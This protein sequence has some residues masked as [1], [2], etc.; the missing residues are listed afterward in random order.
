[1]NFRYTLKHHLTA[2]DVQFTNNEFT[3]TINNWDQIIGSDKPFAWSAGKA[4]AGGGATLANTAAIGQDRPDQPDLKWRPGTYTIDITAN[5]LSTGGSGPFTQFLRVFGSD[6]GSAL[7][8][9]IF[10]IG[11]AGQWD[12][13]AGESTQQITFT[14][15]QEYQKIFFKFDKSGSDVGYDVDFIIDSFEIIRVQDATDDHSI[16]EPDGWKGAKIKLDRDPEYGS[17]IEHYEGAAGGAFIFYGENGEED[18]GINFIKEIEE[19]YGLD[20]NIEFLAEYAPDDTTYTELFSGLLDLTGKNEMPNNKMQVPVIRDGF[21]AKFF[22]RKDTPVNLSD[23]IDLDGNPVDECVPITINLPSQKIRYNG[24]YRWNETVQYP[25]PGGDGRIQLDW[26][27]V[28]VD[29]LD[30]HNLPRVDV[31]STTTFNLIPGIFEAPYDGVYTFDI[32]VETGSFFGGA[33]QNALA[34]PRLHIGHVGGTD[35][36]NYPFFSSSSINNG[37]QYLWVHT[38]NGSFTLAKGQQLAIFGVTD[39]SAGTTNVFGERLNDWKTDV[40]VASTIA[41]VLSGTQT[42]DNYAAGIGDRVLVKN[43]GDPKENGI[44]VVAAGAWSRATDADSASE[45]QDAT[46]FIINGNTNA[47]T[48]WIQNTEDIILG[49]TE[50]TFRTTIYNDTKIVPYPGAGTPE[51]YLIITGETTYKES[52]AQGYLI[53]DLIHGVLARLGLGTD[54]FYSEFLGSTLTTSKQYQEDGAGWPYLILKGLQIRGYTLA[55]KPFFISFKQIWDG[56]NPILNL[57]LGY[58]VSQDSPDYQYIRIEQKAH[59]YEDNISVYF[60]DVLDISSYY[61]QDHI[62]KTIKTG[63]KDWQSEDISGIDDPQAKQTRATRFE[64]VGKEITLES[65]FIAAS[66]AIEKAR[67]TAIEKS[68]DYKHDNKNFIIALSLTGDASPETYAPE[69]NE[70]FDSITNLNNSDARYNLILTPM[71]NF[72]RW[73]NVFGGCLQSYTRSSYRFV[74]GEGNYEMISDYSC[75]GGNQDQAIICDSIAENDDISLTDYNAAIG[76]LH[77]PLLYPINIPMEW[78]EY[79]EIRDNRKKS[80]GVSQTDSGYTVFKIK[81][82]EY[83][84]VNGQANIKAWPKTFLSLTVPNQEFEMVCGAGGGGGDSEPTL[85]VSVNDDSASPTEWGIVFGDGDIEL[86][87]ASPIFEGDIEDITPFATSI[88]TTVHKPASSNSGLA[89]D[90]GSVTWKVN[91][92]TVHNIPFALGHDCFITTTD[93]LYTFTGLSEG[94]ILTIE[95]IEG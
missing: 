95:I 37:G 92:V 77:L 32:R 63:Y 13:G 6:A 52:T 93:L 9:E 82:L 61:D 31:T 75:S 59:F 69:L 49:G 20:S 3:L 73:A 58:E 57:G 86:T 34:E 64:K 74:S 19:T 54:P 48:Y 85:I 39:A 68:S 24:E 81:S 55:E 70:N 83:D 29:D 1:M 7:D 66:L 5:N 90:A 26:D 78:E 43:Q 89:Y 53:H 76:Y 91:G 51:N 65:D 87:T 40:E 80:I 28:V 88:D 11:D 47:N 36:L 72:L 18:G 15:T 33:W 21:W 56:I 2:D 22:S 67:R 35:E 38:F 12:V 41:L 94:D 25:V 45:L 30:K 14:L 84:L 62:F 46:V 71:R 79:E 4:R 27:T 50:I 16:S 17:L 60:S 10:F 8:D 44:Y 42:I 23:D